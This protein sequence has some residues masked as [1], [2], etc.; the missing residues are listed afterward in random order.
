MSLFASIFLSNNLKANENPRFLLV[1]NQTQ[2]R[3]V[4]QEN[5]RRLASK[6][7]TEAGGNSSL[8]GIYITQYL[9]SVGTPVA[10]ELLQ[11]YRSRNFANV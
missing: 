6:A 11:E 5:C 4:L 2:E 9:E 1:S 8:I 10:I 7:R 3:A